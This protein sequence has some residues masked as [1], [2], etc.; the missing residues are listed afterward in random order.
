MGSDWVGQIS[1]PLAPP[2]DAPNPS[3]QQRINRDKMGQA[4]LRMMTQH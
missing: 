3:L 1:C 4:T 2:R